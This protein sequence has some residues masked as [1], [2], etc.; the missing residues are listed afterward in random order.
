MESSH[1]QS[2]GYSSCNSA[3]KATQLMP[4]AAN[5]GSQHW[6]ADSCHSPRTPMA[7]HLAHLR[8]H[9]QGPWAFP[10]IACAWVYTSVC[11]C[12][13]ESCYASSFMCS[14]RMSVYASVCTRIVCVYMYMCLSVC[15]SQSAFPVTCAFEKTYVCASVYQCIACIFVC[16]RV[17]VH[18]YICVYVLCAHSC[19]H[20]CECT[21]VHV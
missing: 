8:V 21:D 19:V 3:A 2:G 13:C 14:G 18:T 12:A 15:L 17:C 11:K 10:E 6:T 4:R 16:T 5:R 1:N 7:F 9:V 20:A